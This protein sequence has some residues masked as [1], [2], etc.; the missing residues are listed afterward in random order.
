MLR[1]I[2]NSKNCHFFW[3]KESLCFKKKKIVSIFF[4]WGFF[5]NYLFSFL[6]FFQATIFWKA[7]KKLFNSDIKKILFQ[8]FPGSPVVKT[9]CTQCSSLVGELIS[10]M[11]HSV[12]RKKMLFHLNITTL[13]I[14]WS[15][16]FSWLQL[17]KRI[18][19]ILE[20]FH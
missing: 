13:Y 19:E 4:L 3:A 9:L 11:P 8:D 2:L 20:Y 17:C 15:H 7:H 16:Y 18:A 5:F 10:C 6:W 1:T 14:I 12:P